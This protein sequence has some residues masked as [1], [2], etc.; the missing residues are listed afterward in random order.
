MTRRG[1]PSVRAGVT[2][3]GSL[4]ETTGSRSEPHHRGY[5]EQRRTYAS[6]KKKQTQ[7]KMSDSKNSAAEEMPAGVKNLIIINHEYKKFICMGK[8]CGRAIKA[9]NLRKHL[10]I[11]HRIGFGVAKNASQ[12]ARGLKWN[13]ELWRNAQLEDGLAPQVGVPVMDAFRCKHCRQYVS[14]FPDDVDVHWDN[15][16]H[17]VTEGYNA[18]KVRIQTWY[19][20]FVDGYSNLYWVVNESLTRDGEEDLSRGL[21]SKP[22]LRE[23]EGEQSTVEETRA[24][25]REYYLE[26]KEYQKLICIDKGCQQAVDPQ[27]AATHL[28]NTHEVRTNLAVRIAKIIREGGAIQKGCDKGIPKDG[29]EPQKGLPVFDGFRC[30]GCGDFKARSVQE[31]EGHCRTIWHE[32][33]KYYIIERVRL[34]SWGG[35]EGSDQRLWVVDERKDGEGKEMEEGSREKA[36]AEEMVEEM[37]PNEVPDDN[38]EESED[39]SEE[40]GQEEREGCKEK[41]NFDGWEGNCFGWKRGKAEDEGWDEMAGDWV[42]MY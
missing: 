24:V 35:W 17:G 4:I 19:R 30:G 36:P 10:Q 12:V 34:Q 27:Y 42:V 2:S 15:H 28:R 7:A 3:R 21:E 13:E 31:V 6:Q 29:M 38:S 41:E 14:I 5:P 40:D 39:W 8:G 16:G 1:G 11:R 20:R 26:N 33:G 18:E 9:V 32:E 22:R 23:D 25:L 37:D